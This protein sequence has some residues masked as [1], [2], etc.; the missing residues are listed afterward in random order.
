MPGVSRLQWHPFSTASSA[1]QGDNITICVKPMGG[2]TR[3]LQKLIIDADST[4]AKSGGCPL[5]LQ[6]FA[7]GPYGLEKDYFLQYKTLVLVA[8]GVGITP[9]MA[10]LRDLLCRYNQTSGATHLPSEV[11]LIWCVPRRADLATLRELQPEHL[12]PN[13]A[14]GPLK[15]DVKAFVTREQPGSGEDNERSKVMNPQAQGFEYAVFNHDADEGFKPVRDVRGSNLW[16]AAVIVAATAGFLVFH[17]IFHN[18]VVR[19]NHHTDAPFFYDHGAAQ[20]SAMGRNGKP[21]PTWATVSFLFISMALGIVVCGGAVLLAWVKF[22]NRGGAT[23]ESSPVKR[24]Q[25]HVV[26]VADLEKNDFSLLKQASV[27]YGGRP[28]LSGTPSTSLLESE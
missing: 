21:F 3:K 2:W 12:F 20:P 5:S 14:G 16:M 11:H 26:G 17:G 8:G 13:F 18:F 7:E 23:P 1:L 19:P 15:L 28:V 6:L 4:N 9:F 24:T 25:G 22:G 27:T 10:V